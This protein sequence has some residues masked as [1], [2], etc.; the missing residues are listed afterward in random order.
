[1]TVRKSEILSDEVEEAYF[2]PLKL[3]AHPPKTHAAAPICEDFRSFIKRA[4][5]EGIDIEAVSDKN[6]LN[7]YRVDLQMHGFQGLPALIRK[8]LRKLGLVSRAGNEFV[9]TPRA[10]RLLGEDQLGFCSNEQNPTPQGR[11]SHSQEERI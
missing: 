5:S 7:F 6:F 4:E 3:E 9:I 1:M 8:K 10:R 11:V 2:A